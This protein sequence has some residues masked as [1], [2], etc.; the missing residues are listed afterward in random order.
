MTLLLDSYIDRL[1]QGIY[2]W[3]LSFKIFNIFQKLKFKMVQ[4]RVFPALVFASMY[5]FSFIGESYGKYSFLKN[6]CSIS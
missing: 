4:C 2:G 5:M 1:T 6:L 3:I